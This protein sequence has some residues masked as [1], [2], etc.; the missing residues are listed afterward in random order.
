MSPRLSLVAA[1]IAGFV[2]A[3]LAAPFTYVNERFGTTV[4]FPDEIFTEPMPRAGEWRRHDMAGGRRRQPRRLWRMF[5]ALEQTPAK[6]PTDETR[7]RS[8][9]GYEVTYSPPARTGSCCPASRTA[10]SSTSAS[11]SAPTT[12]STPC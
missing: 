11:S 3:V 5:N 2:T 7:A 8:D 1:L 4:T 12:S 6:A 9:A 10:R